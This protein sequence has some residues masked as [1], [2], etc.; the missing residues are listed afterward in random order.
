[1]QVLCMQHCRGCILSS[2]QQARSEALRL[3]H[4]Y[5]GCGG[6]ELVQHQS[7]NSQPC[8]SACTVQ[9]PSKQRWTGRTA[10]SRQ[11]LDGLQG[12][13]KTRQQQLLTVC[14]P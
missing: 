13:A 10:R 2:R 6:C 8:L 7:S 4:R 3:Q 9:V 14:M 11:L 5:N 1:M 12:G